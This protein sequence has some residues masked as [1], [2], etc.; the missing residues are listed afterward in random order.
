MIHLMDIEDITITDVEIPPQPPKMKLNFKQNTQP[1]PQPQSKL[2]KFE[3]ISASRRTDI[4][5]FFM[6]RVVQ[7]LKDGVIEVISPAPW[8]VKSLVSLSPRDV[9]CF[10]WWSKDFSKWIQAYQNNLKLFSSYKHIF[11]FTLTGSD[12][13]EPGVITPF[14]ERL[15]QLV[16]LTQLFGVQ[17]IKLRF[18]PIVIWKSPTDSHIH[19]NLEH[20]EQLI[21]TASNLG[22]KKIIF[23]FCIAYPKVLRRMMKHGMILQTLSTEEQKIVLNP[24]LDMCDQYGVQLETCCNSQLIGYRGINSSNCIDGELIDNLCG[25]K[26][27]RKDSGQRKECNCTVSRDVGSYN[28]VCQHGCKYCYANP[29]Q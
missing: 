3:V 6:D 4:P 25:L 24:L 21:Q 5:A 26:T 12:Q 13:L 29:S 27:K 18:D 19:D 28:M 22:I 11:N 7:S 14:I 1:Q 20:F 17:T 2:V 8:C 16:F 9:K 10:V 15:Q 23:A